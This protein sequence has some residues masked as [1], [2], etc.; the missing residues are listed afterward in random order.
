VVIE[1]TGPA[2]KLDSLL[3]ALEPYGVREI[4]KSGTLAIGRGARSITDRAFE[5]AVRSA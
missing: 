3:A 4:V 5:R 1:A 2:A